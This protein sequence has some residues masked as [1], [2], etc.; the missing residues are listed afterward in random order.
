MHNEGRAA[1]RR[2]FAVAPF[3]LLVALLSACRGGD[4]KPAPVGTPAFPGDTWRLEYSTN[5]GI[6]GISQSLVLNE[7]GMATTED[8]RLNRTRQVHLA[9]SDVS[10]IQTLSREA[11]LP[12]LKSDQ[13]LPLPEA[14]VISIKVT[15]GGKTFGVTFNNTLS[16][17][18]MATLLRRLAVIYEANKP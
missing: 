6:S 16:T 12:G 7:K 8:R 4:S 13:G 18:E 15:S 3:M 10:M 17:P 11:N 1:M 2:L 9:P 14:I 5:G